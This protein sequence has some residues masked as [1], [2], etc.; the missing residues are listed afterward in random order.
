MAS[1]QQQP[2]RDS[3]DELFSTIFLF[4]GPVLAFVLAL[5]MIG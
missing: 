4:A 2:T 5:F 1:L 3:S